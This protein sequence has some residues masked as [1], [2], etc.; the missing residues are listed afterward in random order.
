MKNMQNEV[1]L[2]LTKKLSKLFGPNAS[3]NIQVDLKDDKSFVTE[4]DL[5]VSNLVKQ[6][7]LEHP[8]YS[9]YAFFCEEDFQEYVFPC[10]ILDPIDGTRELVKGRPECAVS[11]ALMKTPVID[12][13]SNFAW[14]YNPFS[15]F[16]LDTEMP[17]V[18]TTDKSIQ[19][20]LTFVSRSEFH[21]GHFD[22]YLDNPQID[23]TP[24]GSIAFKLGLLASGACDFIISLAPKNVWD[25]AAG[26]I[27]C[28][29]RGF[30]F[31]ENGKRVTTLDRQNYKGALIWAPDSLAPIILKAF[32]SEFENEKE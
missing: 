8:K 2:E 12:D 4:I 20:I 14:L 11:L 5:F 13:P 6:K 9:Q 3:S 17:F 23:I 30:H 1:I 28:A 25:I 18:P 22:K 16:T 15:G 31:Y 26:T 10:A 27:L 21:K 24:R 7:L 19:K 29:Q 32:E